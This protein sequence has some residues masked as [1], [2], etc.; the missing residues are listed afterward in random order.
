[1][2]DLSKRTIVGGSVTYMI[3]TVPILGYI[4][5]TGGF[6]YSFYYIFSNK[7]SNKKKKLRDLGNMTIGTATSIGSGILGAAIGQ[8]LIPIPVLGT[9]IGG[10][11]GGFLGEF[12][13]RKI[14]GL[15]DSARLK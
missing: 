4:F 1:M 7:F 3:N 11:I 6:T 10:F 2:T 9:F 8:T 12:G 13:G 15:I 14:C 5:I